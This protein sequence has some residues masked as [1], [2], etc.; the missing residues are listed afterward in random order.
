M[1]DRTHRTRAG[2]PRQIEYRAGEAEADAKDGVI[3]G[4]LSTFWVVD[5]YGT[6][7]A[8][9]AFDKTL[10]ERRDKLFLLY[11]HIPSAAIGKLDNLDVDDIGLKHSSQIVDDGAEGTVTLK[12][13]RAGVPFAHSHGFRTIIERPAT[14]SDPLIFTENTPEWVRRD[15]TNAWVIT[16]SKEYEGSVVTFASNDLAV[17]T[18]VRSDLETQTL[19]QTLDDLRNGRLDPAQRALVADLVTAWTAAPEL[20]QQPPR[21]DEEARQDREL[22]LRYLGITLNAA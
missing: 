18:S 9:G 7:F 17:I 1:P 12:R 15:P 3:S 10:S 19:A 21:T 6:A 22:A 5:S 4:Y 14:P 11:Q 2:D 20:H 16:E 8:P 13:L